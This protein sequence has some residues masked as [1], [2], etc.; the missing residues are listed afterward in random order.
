MKKSNLEGFTLLVAENH[1]Q[2]YFRTK[3]RYFAALSLLKE[4]LATEQGPTA[5][6]V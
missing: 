1:K 5:H 2:K 4:K 3:L 6:H